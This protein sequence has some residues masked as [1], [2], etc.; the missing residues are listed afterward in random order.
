MMQILEAIQ[1][2]GTTEA[3]P[4]VK[5]LAGYEFDGLKER[6]LVPISAQKIINACKTCACGSGLWEGTAGPH[7]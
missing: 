3:G 5:A 1:R 7:A 2:A 6:G 4:I